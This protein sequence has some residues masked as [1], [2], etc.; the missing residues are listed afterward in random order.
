MGARLVR[1]PPA[2][3]GHPDWCER[4][5]VCGLGEHRAEPVRLAAPGCG[6]VVLTRVSSGPTG[7]EHA[8]VRISIT[9]PGSEPAARAHLARTVR[10]LSH[11]L[12]QLAQP[13][14]HR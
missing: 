5:H 11:L 1:R 13:A 9:L 6:S 12:E 8:E 4:G 14:Q 7:R 2:D 3:D 10:A